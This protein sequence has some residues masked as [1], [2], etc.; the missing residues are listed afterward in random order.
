PVAGKR[1]LVARLRMNETHV[2][3][4]RS[5]ANAPRC[6]A[7]PSCSE[8]SKRRLKVV[9]PEPDVIERRLMNPGFTLSIYRLHQVDFHLERP[10]ADAQDLFIDVFRSAPIFAFSREPQQVHP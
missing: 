8:P 7:H 9:H 10:G 1:K 6:K 4:R 3:S 2:V 5:T